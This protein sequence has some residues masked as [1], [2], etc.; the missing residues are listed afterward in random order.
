MKVQSKTTTPLISIGIPAH[1]TAAN[2][3]KCCIDSLLAQ[4]YQNLEIVISDNSDT[5]IVKETVEK[6]DDPRINYLRSGTRAT[7]HGNREWICSHFSGEYLVFVDS[8]DYVDTNFVEALYCGANQYGSPKSTVSTIEQQEVI[9]HTV[10]PT[11]PSPTFE[12]LAEQNTFEKFL[13]FDKNGYYIWGKLFPRHFVFNLKFNEDEGP[14]DSIALGRIMIQAVKYVLVKGP[15]Y[16]YY[17]NIQSVTHKKSLE[18]WMAITTFSEYR[19]LCI[20]HE[21]TVPPKIEGRYILYKVK[22]FILK[23]DKKAAR[24]SI[25][26]ARQKYKSTH[27]YLYSAEA[28]QYLLLMVSPYIFKKIFLHTKR[29]KNK[30]KTKVNLNEPI[31]Y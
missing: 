1:N 26:E 31:T 8:D 12:L 5:N 15:K 24:S 9:N 20:K 17:Q 30:S 25:K 4:T 2:L 7:L 22:Y 14:D 23:G 3:L 19:D 6:Y 29:K 27:R 28:K 13:T 16:Y 18:N 11:R 10:L 21:L